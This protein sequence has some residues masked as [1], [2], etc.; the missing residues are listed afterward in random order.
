MATAASMLGQWRLSGVSEGQ[1]YSAGNLVSSMPP[2]RAARIAG[3]QRDQRVGRGDRAK[4][5]EQLDARLVA[6]PG[7]RLARCLRVVAHAQHALALDHAQVRRADALE[8]QELGGLARE[9]TEVAAPEGLHALHEALLRAG[10]EQDHA[11]SV[12]RLLRELVASATSAPTELRLSFAPGTTR[13]APMLAMRGCGAEREDH[14]GPLQPAPAEEPPEREQERPQE[15]P[16]DDRDALVRPLVELRREPHA[17][18][19]QGRVEDEPAVRRVVVGDE[20]DRAGGVRS[21]LPRPRTFQVGRCG[22][23]RRRNQ[24]RPPLT[25]SYTAAAATPPTS[26]AGRRPSS[27]ASADAAF[28]RPSGHQ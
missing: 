15:D 13:L 10:R 27:A 26:A 19:R 7:Q 24:S 14:P 25:S 17:D 18:A 5:A 23:V 6:R 12:R 11:H 21:R 8:A 16:E 4:A 1:W 22:S 9:L 28:R 2:E 20:H 3:T